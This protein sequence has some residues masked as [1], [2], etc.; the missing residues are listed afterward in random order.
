M[1]D[2]KVRPPQILGQPGLAVPQWGG[3]PEMAVP[4]LFEPFVEV[5]AFGIFPGGT[6]EEVEMPGEDLGIHVE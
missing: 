1:S 5:D 2:L 3:Q 6:G 4:L